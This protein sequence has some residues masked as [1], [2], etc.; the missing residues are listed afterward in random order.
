MID[1]YQN[2]PRFEN[3]RFLLRL[4]ELGDDRDLLKVYSDEKAVLLFNDDNCNSG[5]YMTQ[6]EH[7]QGAIKYWLWEYERRGFV[8]MTIVD[9]RSGEAVGTIELFNRQAQDYFTN[10]G[11]LR[12]DLRS[13]YENAVDIEA[14]LA[15]IV[16][17]AFKLFACDKVATKAIPAATERIA[18]LHAL[19]FALSGE[20]VVGH[21]GR[22]YGDYFVLAAQR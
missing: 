10:C 6:L 1:I 13:D 16:L 15:L 20:C 3:E 8:R 18:A 12:L 4:L 14:I 11:L 17:P 2:C 21:D 5:F 19:G 22:Q 9:K 7:I